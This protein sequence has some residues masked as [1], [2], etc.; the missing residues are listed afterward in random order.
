ME[1]KRVH[2]DD[3]SPYIHISSRASSTHRL[4]P[5]PPTQNQSP[6]IVS[7]QTLSPSAPSP[8]PITTQPKPP[9]LFP[10]TRYAV[11]R[12]SP[13]PRNKTISKKIDGT[14]FTGYASLPCS[15]S[16]AHAPKLPS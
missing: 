12:T 13:A 15:L 6:A 5:H 14:P 10:S 16:N 11:H 1:E 2:H 4:T 8:A 7:P 9:S 3:R